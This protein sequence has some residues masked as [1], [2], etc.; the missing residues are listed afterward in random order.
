MITIRGSKNY[1]STDKR[2]VIA[3]GNFDGVHI[4]HQTLI[5]QAVDISNNIGETP[6]VYTFYPHPAKLLSPMEAPPLI[7]TLEQKIADISKMGIKIC[8]V[9]NFTHNFANMSSEAFIKEIIVKRLNPSHVIIGYDYTFGIHR[10]GNCEVMERIA[11]DNGIK[12]DILKP[13][14]EGETLASSTT[15]RRLVAS[16]KVSTANAILGKPFIM[17]GKVISGRGMGTKMNIPTANMA[18]RN[19]LKPADGVYITEMMVEDSKFPSI[20]SIGSNPTFPE[21]EYAIETHI[22]GNKLDLLGHEIEV[23]FLQ[24]IRKQITFSSAKELSDK[25]MED[26]SIAKK[27]HMENGVY[28]K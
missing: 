6:I 9:E 26:I 8:I 2:P 16:G 12:I 5:K 20:T 7:Q 10:Q 19:E 28:E 18:T 27:Y 4:G 14:F 21:S 13:Q 23:A 22:M 3:I 17:I 25:I 24:R 15:I 11:G 1:S